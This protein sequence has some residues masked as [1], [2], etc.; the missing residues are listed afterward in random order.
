MAIQPVPGKK[1]LQLLTPERKQALEQFL[2]RITNFL[3]EYWAHI[4]TTVIGSVVAIAVAIPFLSYFGLDAI[5]KPLFFALHFACAQIPAHSFYILGHQ[6]GLCARN[7][8]IYASMFATGLLFI[9]TK[10]RLPGIPWWMWGILSLPMAWDGFTQ[11]FGLRESTWDLRVI[12]GTLFG[13]GCMWFVLPYIQ[14]ILTEVPPTQQQPM[15]PAA[16]DADMTVQHTGQLVAG[17]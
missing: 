10:K 15:H 6:L 4:I 2:T 12:T 17:N 3:L 9:L 16:N 5:A 14:K 8:S 11:M 1:S 7:L 13:A